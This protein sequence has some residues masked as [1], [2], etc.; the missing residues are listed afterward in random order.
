[1]RDL[2]GEF[3]Q[4]GRA[5]ASSPKAEKDGVES[6]EM[7]DANHRGGEITGNETEIK[8]TRITSGYENQPSLSSSPLLSSVSVPCSRLP[9]LN[10]TPLPPQSACAGSTPA[11][12]LPSMLLALQSVGKCV[13]VK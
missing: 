12:V 10:T 9:V 1:M 3:H 4:I 8:K 13:F 2:A 7:M 11:N 6:K 5:E